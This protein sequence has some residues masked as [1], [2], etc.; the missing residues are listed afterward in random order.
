M[1]NV[2]ITIQEPIINKVIG[3]ELNLLLQDK[4]NVLDIIKEVDKLINCKGSFPLREYGCLLHMVY[5]PFLNRFYKQVAIT[6][7]RDSEMLNLRDN[8]KQELPKD[9]IITLIPTGGCISEWED[10]VNYEEFL[11]AI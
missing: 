1:K 8:P 10:A 7:Y 2:K 5:N 9:A 4:A 3:R 6:A 11:K